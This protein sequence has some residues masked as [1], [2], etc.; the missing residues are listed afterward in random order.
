M[1]NDK[2][3]YPRLF[4]IGVRVFPDPVAHVKE[5]HLRA[6]LRR[7]GIDPVHFSDVFGPSRTCPIVPGGPAAYP[8]DV[9]QVLQI[10]MP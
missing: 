2:K 7:A 5:K 9:E 10:M 8:W 6:G 1:K 4:S 3:N